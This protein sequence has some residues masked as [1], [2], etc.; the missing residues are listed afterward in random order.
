MCTLTLD[1]TILCFTVCQ[2]A[3]SALSNLVSTLGNSL[4]CIDTVDVEFAWTGA[5]E[6]GG[7]CETNRD[8]LVLQGDDENVV[9][10]SKLAEAKINIACTN[11]TSTF[12]VVAYNGV[13]RGLPTNSVQ[14]DFCKATYPG[15]PTDLSS[16]STVAELVPGNEMFVIQKHTIPIHSIS[17]SLQCFEMEITR[18]MGNSMRICRRE[19]IRSDTCEWRARL[20]NLHRTHRRGR[21]RTECQVCASGRRRLDVERED[22]LRRSFVRGC[23]WRRIHIVHADASEQVPEHQLQGRCAFMGAARQHQRRDL[24]PCGRTRR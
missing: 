7:T 14:I 13:V 23:F 6:W 16:P 18:I 12:K 3:P 5:S 22:H 4:S 19:E 8:Y 24:R 21:D 2:I 15:M 20:H 11:G 17:F 1:L 10:Q 9:G